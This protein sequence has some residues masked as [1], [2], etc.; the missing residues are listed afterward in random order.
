MGNLRK[1]FDLCNSVMG[2]QLK[3]GFFYLVEDKRGRCF[4]LPEWAF[5]SFSAEA[6]L[7]FEYKVDRNVWV[8]L[9]NESGGEWIK[10]EGIW[11]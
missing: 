8:S 7:W 4:M 1:K 3:K 5:W 11:L 10:I 6:D 9:V 2:L